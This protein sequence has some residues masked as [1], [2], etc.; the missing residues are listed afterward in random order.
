MQVRA[1]RSATLVAT[2]VLTGC[3]VP[4]SSLGVPLEPH[5]TVAGPLL[6]LGPSIQARLLTAHNRERALVGSQPL[7]WDPQLQ[8][9][10]AVYAE[11]LAATG[12]FQHATA[13]SLQRQGENLWM[14]TKGMFTP[15]SMVANWASGKQHFRPGIFPNVSRTG[16]WT[17]VGHYTQIIWPRTTHVGCALSSSRSFDFLVCRYLPAG[18]A[19]GVRVP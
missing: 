6:N 7:Q 1:V 18:N 3:A 5:R 13:E 4:S 15:E 14:G 12:Q 19:V 11:Q 8:H 2:A 9:A 16:N 17:D 10:A